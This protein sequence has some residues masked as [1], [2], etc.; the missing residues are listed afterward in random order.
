M[1]LAAIVDDLTPAQSSFYL[2]KNF[3]KLNGPYCFYQNV[4]GLSIPANFTILNIAYLPHFSG[5]VIATSLY[6]AITLLKAPINSKNFL[7][8]W[9]MDWIRMGINYEDTLKIL[10]DENIELIARSDIHKTI[11]E[12]YCNRE[13]HSIIDDWNHKQIEEL[14]QWT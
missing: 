10:R 3:N 6:T 2:I 12:D 9:D 14:C 11:I 13:V 1:K 5:I 8:V 7:Y 4:S